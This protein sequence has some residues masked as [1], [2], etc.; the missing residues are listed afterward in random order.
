M[1]F[2]DK[3]FHHSHGFGQV[4]RGEFLSQGGLF[5]YDASGSL[6]EILNFY[7]SKMKH[8][9]YKLSFSINRVFLNESLMIADLFLKTRDWKAVT[10]EVAIQNLLQTRMQSSSKRLIREIIGR[11]DTLELS[12]LD[13]LT[14]ANDADQ[15]RI[16]WLAICRR[17]SLI[18]EFCT[19]VVHE[20]LHALNLR[21]TYADFD[22]FVF[23][24]SVFHPELEAL[25]ESTRKKL[26]QVLFSLMREV[27]ILAD[28]GTIITAQPSPDFVQYIFIRNRHEVFYFPIFESDI[29]S[30]VS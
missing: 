12:E 3:S 18:A 1:L 11:L 8:Q 25:K 14:K 21:L 10:K 4:N 26:R 29:S 28:N 16:L 17:Y 6:S 27:G 15:K 30:M 22:S 13:F 23:A 20:K 2:R 9:K 19:E 7:S 5:S 24:K